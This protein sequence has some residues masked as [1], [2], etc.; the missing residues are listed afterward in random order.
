MK[1]NYKLLLYDIETI[2]YLIYILT[3]IISISLL[4]FSFT[5]SWYYFI[6]NFNNDIVII[7]LACYS[8][9]QLYLYNFIYDKYIIK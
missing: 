5:K 1:I 3:I 8:L 4:I 2:C 6:Y 9:I 7:I